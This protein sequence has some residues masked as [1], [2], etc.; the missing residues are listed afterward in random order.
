LGGK[1]GKLAATFCETEEKIETIFFFQNLSILFYDE[2]KLS[3][4]SMIK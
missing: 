1:G 3:I 4:L 2:R